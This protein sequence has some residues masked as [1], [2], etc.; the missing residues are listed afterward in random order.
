VERGWRRVSGEWRVRN[1][2]PAGIGVAFLQ[3]PGSHLT[4]NSRISHF[5]DTMMLSILCALF[6][7]NVLMSCAG[8]RA[9]RDMRSGRGTENGRRPSVVP[10]S[11]SGDPCHNGRTGRPSGR[12]PKPPL[13][14][15]R[16]VGWRKTAARAARRSSAA[17][18]GGA[19]REGTWACNTEVRRHGEERRRQRPSIGK[20]RYGGGGVH[21]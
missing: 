16:K 1:G 8:M 13:P 20:W 14:P 19:A 4:R 10:V 7:L 5:Q 2:G 12:N 15:L 11:R 6:A 9:A 17:G 21:G 3:S 18:P